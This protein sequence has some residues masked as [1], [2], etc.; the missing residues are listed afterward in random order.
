MNKNSTIMLDH[1]LQAN[2]VYDQTYIEKQKVR[3][4]K[5]IILV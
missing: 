5:D 2:V 4:V 3:R 1:S